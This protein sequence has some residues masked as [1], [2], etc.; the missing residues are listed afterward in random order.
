MEA[1]LPTSSLLAAFMGGMLALAAPCCITFLLPAFLAGVYKARVAVLAMTFVFGLG[2]A[3]VILPIALGVSALSRLVSQWHT[4]VFILGGVFLLFLGTWSL[5]GRNLALP[6]KPSAASTGPGVL[7]V[8]GLGVFSGAAS[9]ST[10]QPGGALQLVTVS[11]VFT[12]L[13]GALPEGPLIGVLTLTALTSS[14]PQAAGV[15][16]AYVFGMVFPLLVA[17]YLWD[18]YDLSQNVIFRGRF[19][20]LR[21]SALSYRI[22]STNLVVGVLFWA[23]GLLILALTFTGQLTEATE[24]QTSLFDAL[25]SLADGIIERTA[26]LPGIVAGLLLGA[27]FLFLSRAALRRA[28]PADRSPEFVSGSKRSRARKACHE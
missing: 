12:S 4:E 24:A 23:M 9:S 16:G 6:F 5:M 2:I 10:A 25:N 28:R 19:L 18:R 20:E 22:H 21:L 27:T 14:L 11:K 7:S 1:L 15:A 17:A 26:W 13:A 8:F 3:A